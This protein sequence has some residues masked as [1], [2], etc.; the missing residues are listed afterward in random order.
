MNII[1][2]FSPSAFKHNVD[3]ADIRRAFDTAEYD[4]WFNE[5]K[6][7][8]KDKYLMIGFDRNGNLLEI[9][10]NI[11]D[12]TT[13]NVFHAMRCRNIFHHLLRKEV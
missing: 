11:I 2:E 3:E 9:L 12:E 5:A 6:G 7:Q 1:I 13:I 4:G 10:Y 8:D